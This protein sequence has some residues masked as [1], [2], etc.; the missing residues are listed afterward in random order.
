MSSPKKRRKD[1]RKTYKNVD[2]AWDAWERGDHALAEKLSQ[3]ALAQGFVNPRIWLERAAMLEARGERESA[4]RTYERTLAL[5]PGYRDARDGI[6]RLGGNEGG[7]PPEQEHLSSHTAAPDPERLRHV[8]WSATA[9][10]LF[11]HGFA[12][13]PQVMSGDECAQL[14]SLWSLPARFEHEVSIDD[15]RGRLA[16]RFFERPLPAVVAELRAGVYARAVGIANAWQSRLGRDHFPLTHEGFLA[17]CAAE[18]Q[19]R[20]TPILLRYDRGGFNAPHRDVYGSVYFPLQL[21]VTLGPGSSD[22]GGGGEL[23]LVDERPGRLRA[24][25]M[26]TSVGDAVLFATRERP[27]MI[28]GILG[29]QSVLHGVAEVRAPERFAVGIPF[30]EF[31]GG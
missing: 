6:A 16:Y 15:D 11:R 30:H 1:R 13:L 10:A 8:D 28:A 29:L 20:T 25:R 31:R 14:R 5:A 7:T 18:G 24:R 27:V 4:L 22:E 23:V 12:R 2:A 26:P 21:V 3:R 19:Q 17:R 9:D